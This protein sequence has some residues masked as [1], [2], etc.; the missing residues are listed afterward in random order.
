[1]L[2]VLDESPLSN[3]A[4]INSRLVSCHLLRST[5]FFRVPGLTQVPLRFCPLSGS[6]LPFCPSLCLLPLSFYPSH[7]SPYLSQ[8]VL[9]PGC[10]CLGNHSASGSYHSQPLPLGLLCLLLLYPPRRSLS[11]MCVLWWRLPFGD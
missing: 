5:D 8:A 4:W 9:L 3:L 7:I 6:L 1:M 2:R 10:L 11:Y